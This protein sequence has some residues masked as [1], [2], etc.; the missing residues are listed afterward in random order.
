MLDRDG[1]QEAAAFLKDYAAQ[2]AIGSETAERARARADALEADPVVF[3]VEHADEILVFAVQEDADRYADAA[4]EPESQWRPFTS[5]PDVVKA[6][7]LAGAAAQ[8]EIDAIDDT[9][10]D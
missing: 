3:A 9:E 1:R 7:V 6:S 5:R 2:F 4:A 8:A 10:E